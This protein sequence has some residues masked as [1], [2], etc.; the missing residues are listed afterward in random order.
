[1]GAH[2]PLLSRMI[3]ACRAG[4]TSRQLREMPAMTSFVARCVSR[5]NCVDLTTFFS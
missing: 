4:F 3:S 2:L 5:D 1:M